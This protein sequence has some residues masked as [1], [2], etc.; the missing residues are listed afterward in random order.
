MS[1]LATCHCGGVRLE[2]AEPPVTVTDCNCSIC[3]R[4]GVLWAYYRP[5]QVVISGGRTETYR[6]G[7]RTLAFHRC[8]TCGC[9]THWAPEPPRAAD[10]MGINARL[11]GPAVLAR[12]R[13]RHL[14]GG[15]SERYID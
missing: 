8:A 7:A 14:D 10:R 6:W 13:V 11:L 2:L 15:G 12:A 5:D 9:V 3:R 4:Y 1:V